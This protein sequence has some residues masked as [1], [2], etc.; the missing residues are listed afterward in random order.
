MIVR[1]MGEG[2]YSVPDEHLREINVHDEALAAA[3]TAGDEANFSSALD[4]LLSR[5]RA[6]GTRLPDEELVASDLVL[7]SPSA[8]IEEVTELSGDDG[9]IPG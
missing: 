5:V 9:L 6:V 4:A 1:I 7:P 8:T 2:Q 3:V